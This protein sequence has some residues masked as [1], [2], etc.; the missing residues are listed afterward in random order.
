MFRNIIRCVHS[1]IVEKEHEKHQKYQD[2][3]LE[4]QWV[5]NFWTTKFAPIIIDTNGFMIIIMIS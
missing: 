2:L 5:W 1:N 4:L 3:C